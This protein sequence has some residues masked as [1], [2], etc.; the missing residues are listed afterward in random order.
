[1]ELLVDDGLERQFHLAACAGTFPHPDHFGPFVLFLHEGLDVDEPAKRRRSPA[2]GLNE[3]DDA[4]DAGHVHRIR[5]RHAR[6]TRRLLDREQ[7]GK[8]KHR[9]G[10]S[11]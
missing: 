8:D 10:K 9:K 7:P 1:M 4:H 2:A 5:L 6:R 11:L 3:G